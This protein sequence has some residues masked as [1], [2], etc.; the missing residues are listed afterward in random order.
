VA[1]ACAARLPAGEG[2]RDVGAACRRL[3]FEVALERHDRERGSQAVVLA[4]AQE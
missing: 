1:E 4:T 3:G 2:V